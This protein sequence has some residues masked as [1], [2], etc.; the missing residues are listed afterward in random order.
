LDAERFKLDFPVLKRQING[1]DIIYLDSA[2]MSLKPTQVIN[3]INEYY[4]EYP[5]CGGRSVHKLATQVTISVDEARNKMQRF[6]NAKEE[7]EIIFLKNA[8][9]GMNLVAN[10]LDF[11]ENDKILITDKEHNSNLVPWITI[12]KKYDTKTIVVPSKPDNTFD[13]EKFEESMDKGVKLVSMVHTSNLN[14]ITIPAQEMIKIAHDYDALV[15]LDGAQSA[16]HKKIDV[17]ALDVDLFVLSVHKMCGPTGVGV[18][19]GKSEVLNDLKPFIVGGSTVK[20]SSYTDI[21]FLPPPEKFEAGLQNYA[22]IIGSGAAVD[23][24]MNI[25]LENIAEHETHL[26][27][28]ITKRLS[29]FPEINII[30]PKDPK[31]RGCVFSFNITGMDSHDI[32]MILDEMANIMIRSGMQCV[33]SWY[34]NK[35]L[36]G[37]ARA[38]V[39][40]YNTDEDVKIFTEHVASIIENFQ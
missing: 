30:A 11:M 18:L 5:S 27:D 37:S 34:K 16:P 19:Y 6:L 23:Y 2:C 15:M 3:K 14:G 35:N 17:Q 28:I 29:G 9:E 31:L 21:D 22:G 33:H 10:S 12:Q 20:S 38:S 13:L 1:K 8:T 26:N 7:N 25:G 36:S 32:A 39:Y 4:H 40:L 24:L